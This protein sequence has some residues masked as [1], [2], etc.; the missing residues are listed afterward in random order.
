MR[1]RRPWADVDLWEFFLS[2]RAETKFPD[3]RRKGLASRN[4]LRGRI[5]DAIVDRKGKTVFNDSIMERIDYAAL[6]RWLV[7]PPCGWRGRL[8]ALGKASGRRGLRMRD[9]MWARDLAAIHAFVSLG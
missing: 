2:L 1:V 7:D 3:E 4:L 8:R 6:R 5:P 9:L